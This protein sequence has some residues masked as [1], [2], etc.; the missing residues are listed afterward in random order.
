MKIKPLLTVVICTQPI[1]RMKTLMMC[2]SALNKQSDERFEVFLIDATDQFIYFNE[3]VT[4]RVNY[5]LSIE[6][7]SEKN[8]SISRNLGIL[9]AKT[10]YV[11]FLDDDAIPDQN[12][13]KH[14][15]EH[16]RRYSD[17]VILGGYNSSLSDSYF[18][19]YTAA[20]YSTPQT[21]NQ[22]VNDVSFVSGLNFTL[23]LKQYRLLERKGNS[24]RDYYFDKRMTFAGDDTEFCVFVQKDLKGKIRCDFRIQVKHDF[25]SDFKNFVYRWFQF[26]GVDVE[27][28][29]TH[30][31]F[32][33]NAEYIWLISY[34]DETTGNFRLR[35]KRFFLPLTFTFTSTKR[36]L[37]TCCRIGFSYFPASILAEIAYG[38]GL[39][40]RLHEK[41]IA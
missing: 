19:K 34:F 26:G 20:Y 12:W 39:L 31:D 3:R 35:K 15:L 28:F 10:D 36:A 17:T 18:S 8:L 11:V 38:S 14:I 7:L 29:L 5:K 13:V 33:F 9:K 40:K 41:V 21:N 23:N 37:E 22:T 30:P 4:F 2:L 32:L 25:R 27:V 6:P 24:K 1:Q 16:F